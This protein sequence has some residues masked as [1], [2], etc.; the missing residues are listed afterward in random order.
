MKRIAVLVSVMFYL[1]SVAAGQSLP[2]K[3]TTHPDV[4]TM[5]RT[6]LESYAKQLESSYS[7]LRTLVANLKQQLSSATKQHAASLS[8]VA[9]LKADLARGEKNGD[10]KPENAKTGA[11]GSNTK[12]TAEVPI[13]EQPLPD[14]PI[15]L[16][17]RIAQLERG[18][19]ELSDQRKSAWNQAQSLADAS[20]SDGVARVKYKAWVEVHRGLND[21][22]KK[23]D[24]AIDAATEKLL[25]LEKK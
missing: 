9:R 23:C 5:T 11:A 20:L 7:E 1:C 21:D 18:R 22:L 3:E 17:I 24:A 13:F 8:E 14:D 12:P 25:R 19:N 4:A 10:T 15:K 6:E 2:A 16:Q